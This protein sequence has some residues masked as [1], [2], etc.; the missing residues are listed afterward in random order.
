M[1]W[2]ETVPLKASISGGRKEREGLEGREGREEDTQ[3]EQQTSQPTLSSLFSNL[4]DD[5]EST[6]HAHVYTQSEEQRL[7]EWESIDYLAPSSRVYTDWLRRQVRREWDRWVVMAMIGVAMGGVGFS[8]HLCI[9][10]FSYMKYTTT[11]W[12]LHATGW[13]FVSWVWNVSVSLGLVWMSAW[14]VVEVCEGAG[15]SG[16][17]GLMA[18]LNGC[19]V[20]GMFEVKTMVVKYL[21]SILAVSS[22]LAVGPE[23]PV[24]VVGGILASLVR[25]WFV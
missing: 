19:D 11:R 16:V 13:L 20:G 6:S 1:N 3:R 17:P 14:L 4:S 12:L 10:V 2:T 23:G 22:G 7:H 15:G 5:L 24:M 9:S 25:V 21:S 18:Y 8:L